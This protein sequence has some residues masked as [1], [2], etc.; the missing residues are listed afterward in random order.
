[1][2]RARDWPGPIYCFRYAARRAYLDGLPVAGERVPI[3]NTDGQTERTDPVG[4]TV[5]RALAI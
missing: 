2:G 4:R 5:R 1:M 3:N